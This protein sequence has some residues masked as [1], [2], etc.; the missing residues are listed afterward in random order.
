MPNV[1]AHFAPMSLSS[2][3][4]AFLSR[5]FNTQRCRPKTPSSDVDGTPGKGERGIASFPK[6]VC[7]EIAFVDQPALIGQGRFGGPPC[8]FQPQLFG[9]EVTWQTAQGIGL[10]PAGT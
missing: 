3:P 8:L 10:V 9:G 1:V 4:T 2:F 5:S 7:S 6:W